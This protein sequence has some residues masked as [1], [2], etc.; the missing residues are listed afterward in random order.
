MSTYYVNSYAVLDRIDLSCLS[1]VPPAS[2][3]DA[4]TVLPLMRTTKFWAMN[5]GHLLPGESCL[6]CTAIYILIVLMLLYR[7]SCFYYFHVM[8]I[9]C[10]L[11]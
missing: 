6:V 7:D 10:K 1:D 11:C 8:V 4:E 9:I 5:L 2:E 3:M